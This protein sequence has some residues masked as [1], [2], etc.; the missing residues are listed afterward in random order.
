MVLLMTFIVTFVGTV[1]NLGFQTD[2]ISHWLKA[3]GGSA[4]VV[5]LPIVML[6]IPLIKK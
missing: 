3:W 1:K 4:F 5:T 2:F 6:I